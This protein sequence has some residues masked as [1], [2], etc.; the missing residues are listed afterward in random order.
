MKYVLTL[1]GNP[2]AADLVAAADDA[3]A[4][5]APPDWLAHDQACDLF[6]D[7][8][9]DEARARLAPLLAEAAVDHCL[10]PAAS[11]RKRLLIADMDSTMITVE[12]VD[13]L[14]EAAGVGAR[15]REITEIAMRG[16]LDFVGALRQR[17]AMLEG[18]PENALERVFEQD[19][20]FSPGGRTL[21]QTMRAHGAHT[22]LISGGFTFFTE[23]VAGRIG[24]HEHRANRLELADGRLTGTVAEPILGRESKVSALEELTARLGVSPRDA[25]CIG[26]GANDIGMIEAAGL[27]VAWRGKPV[28]R[29]AADACIDHGDLGTAL[30]FQG[31]RED[32]FST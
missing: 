20:A 12:C 23:R 1:V 6:T 3:L 19:I 7:L 21:V 26:D 11:R 4:A 30:F 9:A 17:V 13:V 32:E 14:A 22:A 28:V 2:L 25:L 31:Y 5:T 24:F 29:A 15:V 16:E 18:L 10:Q 27:G 8:T